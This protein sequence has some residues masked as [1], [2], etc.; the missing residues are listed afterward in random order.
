MQATE[1]NLCHQLLSRLSVRE[2][3]CVN[4][5]RLWYHELT[6]SQVKLFHAVLRRPDMQD[7]LDNWELEGCANFFHKRGSVQVIRY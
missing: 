5:G 6:E 7:A 3:Q 4:S 1:S 2:G